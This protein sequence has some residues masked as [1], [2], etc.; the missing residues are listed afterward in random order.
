MGTARNQMIDIER[1]SDLLKDDVAIFLE[2]YH[3]KPM[4]WTDMELEIRP[5]TKL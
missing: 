1:L 4:V 3:I 2:R 5:L